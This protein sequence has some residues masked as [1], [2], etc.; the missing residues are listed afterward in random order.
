MLVKDNR[1]LAKFDLKGIPPGPRGKS[2]INVT[3]IVDEKHNV[4][5][6]AKLQ[7]TDIE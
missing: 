3:F 6:S 1:F 4:I 5:V 2:Q 7:G